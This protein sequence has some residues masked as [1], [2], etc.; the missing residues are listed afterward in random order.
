MDY[1]DYQSS[2]EI[3]QE[4]LFEK[5]I[6][7][8]PEREKRAMKGAKLGKDI[9]EIITDGSLWGS[10]VGAVL[11]WGAAEIVNE[12]MSDN[13]GAGYEETQSESQTPD[14]AR[15][16]DTCLCDDEELV[17]DWKI[18]KK[19]NWK[20]KECEEKNDFAE[21]SKCDSIHFRITKKGNYRCIA[22][23]KKLKT[24]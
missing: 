12:A 6:E 14:S 7:D 18:T 4:Y 2:P 22:C 13:D 23:D 9:G 3:Y 24:D 17:S 11:G 19:G 20:C 15:V 10:V 1:D 5:A 16:C 21:C 8:L